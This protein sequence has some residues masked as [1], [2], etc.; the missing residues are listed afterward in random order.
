M[1]FV[2]QNQVVFINISFVEIH[3]PVFNNGILWLL[4]PNRRMTELYRRKL[5]SHT[6]KTTYIEIFS[7]YYQIK[8]KSDCI[9]HAPIGLDLNRSPFGFKSIGAW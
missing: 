5:H 3:T 1:A 9:Y 6:G 7:K 8:T 2:N 4:N